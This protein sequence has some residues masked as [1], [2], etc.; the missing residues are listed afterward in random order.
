LEKR[1]KRGGGRERERE[2][3]IIKTMERSEREVAEER[4]R[5]RDKRQRQRHRHG[6]VHKRPDA[7]W[8]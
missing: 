2:G 6:D 8:S 7:G 5:D 3:G 4:A 1:R